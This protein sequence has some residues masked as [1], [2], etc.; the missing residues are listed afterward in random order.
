MNADDHGVLRLGRRN[1]GQ[2]AGLGMCRRNQQQAEG[3]EY[4]QKMLCGLGQLSL[5]STIVFDS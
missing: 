2:R 1:V 3:A 4:E 5:R